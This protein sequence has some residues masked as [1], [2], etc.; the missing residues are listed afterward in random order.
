MYCCLHN[1]INSKF[2][3]PFVVYYGFPTHEMRQNASS[4]KDNFEITAA[5]DRWELH[6]QA[7]DC[8]YTTKSAN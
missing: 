7:F 5:S 6:E 3:L 8:K 2:V 1:G 4:W